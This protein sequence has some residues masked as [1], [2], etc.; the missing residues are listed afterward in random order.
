MAQAY[1]FVLLLLIP[2]S[3]QQ[4]PD[5]S[6]L[7]QQLA[8]LFTTYIHGLGGAQQ[9]QQ[10]LDTSIRTIMEV[11]GAVRVSS[12]A[13]Q[14]E[15]LL[16]YYSNQLLSSTPTGPDIEALYWASNG[17]VQRFSPH[18]NKT[19]SL[20]AR[21][22]PWFVGSVTP[23]KDVVLLLDTAMTPA[24]WNATLHGL[25]S[26][27]HSL[28]PHDYFQAV[29]VDGS[30][31]H[32]FPCGSPS[33]VTRASLDS[34]R[35][36]M[37]WLSSFS[38]STTT[39]PDLE[40]G[41]SELHQILSESLEEQNSNCVKLGLLVSASPEAVSL[42]NVLQEE[43][44]DM[45]LHSWLLGEEAVEAASQHADD[46]FYRSSG[47]FYELS[48]SHEGVWTPVPNVEE[49]ASSL[50]DWYKQVAAGYRR[51]LPLWSLGLGSDYSL[52]PFNTD[53]IHPSSLPLLT[54]SLPL[55]SNSTTSYSVVQEVRA[56]DVRLDSI[57]AI[58]ER[59][60]VGFSYPFLTSRFGETLIHPRAPPLDST[61]LSP[62]QPLFY[63]ISLVETSFQQAQVRS[64]LVQTVSG[65]ASFVVDLPTQ[66]GDTGEGFDLRSIS[67]HFFWRRVE[68]SP[69][70]VVFALTQD[71]VQK[72]VLEAPTPHSPSAFLNEHLLLAENNASAF[73]P[74]GYALFQSDQL[75]ENN[76]DFAS[77]T[78]SSVSGT[79]HTG[80]FGD[81]AH[82]FERI[83]AGD[84]ELTQRAAVHLNDLPLTPEALSQT[85]LSPAELLLNPAFELEVKQWIQLTA[86][87]DN[88]W[89]IAEYSAFYDP[90]L[91]ELRRHLF[92]TILGTDPGGLLRTWPGF[93]QS[94]H[95]A[96]PV[97]L[98]WF[99]RGRAY[100]DR[101]TL[102]QPF[103][104]LG[105]NDEEGSTIGRTI[106]LA[107][108]LYYD[109]AQP[110]AGVAAV[111]TTNMEY[112]GFYNV[113]L[114][115]LGCP[116]ERS[117]SS[118][119][120]ALMDLGGNLLMVPEFN[121]DDPFRFLRND[122][123]RANS[124]LFVGEREPQLTQQLIASQVLQLRKQLNYRTQRVEYSYTLNEDVFL[125][126]PTIRGSL[127]MSH[128]A[129]YCSQADQYEITAVPG[130]NVYL[131]LFHDYQ[132]VTGQH[133]STVKPPA[134]T[135]L[136]QDSCYHNE[137]RPL[138]NCEEFFDVLETVLE[139]ELRSAAGARC[140]QSDNPELV[141]IEWSSPE[142]IIISS[143][144][145]VAAVVT[146][147]ILV[148]LLWNRR[149][150]VV[151][152]SS[153]M[154]VCFML[155]GAQLGY[156][157]ILLGIGKPSAVGCN[158]QLWL[159]VLCFL[160][161]F[162]SMIIKTYR[163]HTIFTNASQLRRVVMTN[164]HVSGYLLALMIVPLCLLTVWTILEPLDAI[165][166]DDH[167]DEDK[168]TL[169]C[170]S[171]NEQLALIL[172]GLLAA[173]AGA[174]ILYAAFLA[175]EVRHIKKEIM[176]GEATYMAI[177]LYNFM[178]LG[179]AGI[180]L[181]VVLR[182]TPVASFLTFSLGVLLALFGT[183]LILFVPKLYML[184][185][186]VDLLRTSG[187]SDNFRPTSVTEK[188]GATTTTS[189]PVS[190]AEWVTVSSEVD[191]NT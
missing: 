115:A 14:L 102:T 98:A 2:L 159:G 133:C 81:A 88:Y 142:A 75:R 48:C 189:R 177:G 28:L 11:D 114:A 91:Q 176:H 31:T 135:R 8:T 158:I 36:M 68:D 74:P 186:G 16:Q 112:V 96:N 87:M 49:V 30:H 182:S 82:F 168:E 93:P 157:V 26:V 12:L 70:I 103:D 37:E 32:R 17:R 178:I 128:S 67:V 20:D 25:F 22:M 187:S 164:Q 137:T 3:L 161:V 58:L 1:L 169:R 160:I 40:A 145:A 10:L 181:Y 39:V 95:D 84:L 33:G 85:S 191:Y 15:S 4:R 7:A 101:I 155:L 90:L 131:V 106:A 100:P 43:E 19:L 153:V 188:T 138:P 149:Q 108:A 34:K 150:S 173:Y 45:K 104:T 56:L 5:P 53:T 42:S 179:S 94:Y 123:A 141:W 92:F 76:I 61:P 116:R 38:V 175:F 110:D 29:V 109:S 143:L 113:S 66:R 136:Q 134:S 21:S 154:F 172:G 120:C 105:L 69:F 174:M 63:D 147:V 166:Y 18:S 51:T 124:L 119:Q 55:Y 71:D 132:F 83:R 118:L 47:G 65:H 140:E 107:K 156:A 190:G 180:V 52:L 148:V 99:Q 130:L 139:Q 126:Q 111:L 162:G 152:F 60:E 73:V 23:R 77:F 79:Y 50:A 62:S 117:N 59:E 122:T 86:A 146:A 54:V 46:D 9:A 170:G 127:Q 121:G 151:R 80:L 165:S 185:Q 35:A 27:I 72:H 163:I 13:T 89:R 171:H 97:T 57:L 41:V 144:T 125:D 44:L 78:H 64:Q 167:A 6:Q 184:L 183:L 24:F 129:G